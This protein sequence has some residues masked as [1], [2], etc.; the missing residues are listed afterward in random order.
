MRGLFGPE[1]R[2]LYYRIFH[3]GRTD[4]LY[5]SKGK[6]VEN[7]E[8][9]SL[10]AKEENPE[11]Y[12]YNDNFINQDNASVF[13]GK[14]VFCLAC[15][16]NNKI[17]EYAIQNGART[18]LGFGDIPTSMDEFKDNGLENVSNDIVRFMKT[19]LNYIVKRSLEYSIANY[20]D[21]EQL[22]NI[23]HFLINQ[24]IS[25]YLI[26]R[27]CN[28]ERYILTDYLYQLKK[29]IRVFGDTKIKLIQ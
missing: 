9:V 4:K 27:K 12:Y 5:G 7:A 15:N 16:S 8:F 23:L 20:H 26:A 3:H 11:D 1:K 28:K 13:S 29:E 17:A 10:A 14:K 18:F 22:K 24:T 2:G 21:F 19:E 6:L 25:E